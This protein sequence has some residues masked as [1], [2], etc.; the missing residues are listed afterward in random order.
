MNKKGLVREYIKKQRYFN[1]AGVIKETGLSKQVAKNYLY[2]L[3]NEGTVF[4]A[5]RGVYSSVTQEFHPQEKSRVIEIRQLL[6]KQFPELDFLIWNT[7]YFQPYYHHQ[8][9]HNITF[10]EV[11]ADAMRP[12]ADSIS[13]NYRFVMIEKA[14][15]VAPKGFDIIRDPIIVRMLIKGSPRKEHMPSLEKML[16]D[17]FVIKDK[18]S[19][20]PDGDYWELWR[21]IDELFR[22]NVISLIAYAKTRRYFQGMLS[23]LIDNI[24]LNKVTFGAYLKY[25]GKVTYN[26]GTHGK[27][28]T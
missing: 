15:R 12:V 6:K 18:Y 1:L 27:A 16:V 5:G 3:K 7:L 14:S 23:Q 10:V 19:T 13:R 28:N 25:A 17:L 11:E 24:G 4:S 21:S 20:M 2:T 26:K 8:Q 22:V 9:T